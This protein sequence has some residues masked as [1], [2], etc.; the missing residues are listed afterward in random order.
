MTATEAVAGRHE[1]DA[2]GNQRW[3]DADYNLHR[4]NDLPAVV[5][6][7]G[8]Q[9]WWQHGQLHRDDGQPAFVEANGDQFWYQHGQC[10]RDGDR[11]AIVRADGDQ[12]WYQ[13]GQ[14]HRDGGRPAVVWGNGFMEWWVDSKKTGNTEDM[15]PPP[16]A[17]FEGCGTGLVTKSAAKR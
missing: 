10:H 1:T 7:N 4:D 12:F 6:S 2:E 17:V 14:R 3:Y 15:G 16:D 9:F 8:D 11:P 13:H 5:D